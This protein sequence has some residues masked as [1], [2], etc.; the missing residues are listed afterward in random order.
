[1]INCIIID[2]EPLAIKLLE[3]HISKIEELNL[4]G[5][6]NSA[7]EAYRILQHQPV[8]LMFL[9]I[10]MPDLNGIEFLKSLNRKPKT[11][12]TTA[13]RDYA[14]E[15]FELEAVDY[16]LKPITFD[17]FF[18]SV[19]RIMRTDVKDHDK[20]F[21]IFKSEGFNVKILLKD[22]IYIESQGNDIKICQIN[23]CMA[24]SKVTI[25]EL[26]ES[27]IQKGFIRIHRSYMVNSIWITA[28]N[29]NEILAGK[30]SIPVGRSYRKEFE[31]FTKI[32]LAKS[33]S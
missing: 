17:R 28:I 3:N 11:I 20:D 24:V 21:M 12:F 30:I 19:E 18:K 33:S 16:L 13:Y 27:L 10:Q 14:V 31:A 1:M 2:D 29:T 32:F 7:L 4:V 9:D 23:G 8:D 15:G 6:G 22:I 26:A 5:I 25:S